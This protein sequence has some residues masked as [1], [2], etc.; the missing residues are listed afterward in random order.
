M[1]S[2]EK[3][4]GDG[5]ESFIRILGTKLVSSSD[6]KSLTATQ[7]GCLFENEMK[8]KY[9]RQ[10]RDTNCGTECKMN[11]IY[12]YCDCIPYYLPR[13]GKKYMFNN[14]LS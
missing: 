3:I 9:F 10:Y 2:I 1:S 7:R 13:T 5:T 8:L 11:K 12:Q 6:V 14:L 4:L